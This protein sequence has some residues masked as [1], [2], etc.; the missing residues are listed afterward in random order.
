FYLN[1]EFAM[2]E[3]IL[4]I[5]WNDNE[6]IYEISLIGSDEQIKICWNGNTFE[7]K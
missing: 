1:D 2:E 7:I 4:N 6:K 5:Q 3:D